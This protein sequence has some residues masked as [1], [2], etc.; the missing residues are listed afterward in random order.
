MAR[1]EIQQRVEEQELP[2]VARLVIE[3]RSDGSRTVARGALEQA[4]APGEAA[5]RVAVEAR[6]GSPAALA[7]DLLRAVMSAPFQSSLSRWTGRE[8]QVAAGRVVDGADQPGL[9]GRVRR[10]LGGRLRRR[11]GGR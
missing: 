11:F 1:D 10:E 6:G 7:L 4:L 2:V 3:I 9:L 5:E 8:G